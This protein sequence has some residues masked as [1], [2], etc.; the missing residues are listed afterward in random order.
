MISFNPNIADPTKPWLYAKG[1]VA[2]DTMDVE[3]VANC[4]RRCVWSGIVWT[5]GERRE[6][7]FMS[8]HWAVLDFDAGYRLDQCQLDFADMIHVIG[9][10]KSHTPAHHRFRIAIP[11]DEPIRSL[12]IYRASMARL[13]DKKGADE[14]CKDGARFFWPCKEIVSVQAEGYTME[15]VTELPP[16]PTPRPVM[17]EGIAPWTT[18]MLRSSWPV[19]SRNS[20][21]HRVAKDLLR[22]GQ[23]EQLALATIKASVTYKGKITPQIERELRQAVRSARRAVDNEKTR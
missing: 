17:R 18:M 3:R 20:M 7:A 2:V 16:E 23:T 11:W 15:I 22:A 4:M 1:F 10:T 13:I 5:G 12:P 21:A 19:G 9:T 6:A 8:S 14:A